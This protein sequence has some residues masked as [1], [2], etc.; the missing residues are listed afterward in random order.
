MAIDVHAH[1]L[2]ASLL[3]RLRQA[4]SDVGV[5]V[6]EHT[7]GCPCLRFD[8]G[9]QTRPFFPRL[10]EAPQQ[11]MDRMAGTGI[12]RQILSG[13]TDIFGFGLEPAKGEAWH[14]LMN[15]TLAEF[16]QQHESSFSALVSGYLPDAASAVIVCVCAT[17]NLMS[18]CSPLAAK[19]RSSMLR[20]AVDFE[21][22]RIG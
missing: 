5:Q 7:P 20:S 3:E 2:P 9:L 17:S 21:F 22:S 6:C 15:E 13:W 14:R 11:R 19:V 8:D 4:G 10:V 16:C 1:Y 12:E 18:M